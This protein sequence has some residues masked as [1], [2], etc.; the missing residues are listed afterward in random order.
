[1]QTATGFRVRLT[2]EVEVPPDRKRPRVLGGTR[3]REGASG[4]VQPIGFLRV[5]CSVAALF[6]QESA[7]M[8]MTWQCWAKQ[9]MRAAT[10][11]AFGKTVLHCLDDLC[12]LITTES[13]SCLRLTRL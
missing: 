7:S 10:Q 9:S 2:H 5:A 8:S 3:G 1:M 12:A 11:A 13:V 4:S 6:R